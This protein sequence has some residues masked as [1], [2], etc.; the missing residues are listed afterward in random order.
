MLIIRLFIY[1]LSDEAEY[2]RKLG[3]SFK[4][5]T[6]I[7]EVIKFLIFAKDAPQPLFDGATKTTVRK[8]LATNYCDF[9]AIDYHRKMG[10]TALFAC[11]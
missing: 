5:P 4:T 2:I 1:I 7:K 6:V 9:F 3:K 11:V 10:V 8:L